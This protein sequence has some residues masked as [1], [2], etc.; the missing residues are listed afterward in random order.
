MCAVPLPCFTRLGQYR[1]PDGGRC[2]SRSRTHF[3]PAA[4][5]AAS[6]GSRPLSVRLVQVLFPFIAL[7][8]FVLYYQQ[9]VSV[10]SILPGFYCPGH[11]ADRHSAL[12]RL[13]Q[14]KGRPALRW[15]GTPFY[16]AHRAVFPYPIRRR[17]SSHSSSRTA[18]GGREI[19]RGARSCMSRRPDLHNFSFS[20]CL[21]S[22]PVFSSVHRTD[23]PRLVSSPPE[24]FLLRAPRW[25]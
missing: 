11:D 24:N 7:S 6:S 14:D 25:I 17:N 10:S 16:P 23:F 21:G 1:G 22:F 13:V 15:S 8:M 18:A 19:S 4:Q 5:R 20:I 12:L 2:P 3:P 9:N